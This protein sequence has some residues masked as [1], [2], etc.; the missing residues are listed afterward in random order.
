MF[1][2]Y[3]SS[4]PFINCNGIKFWSKNNQQHRDNDQPAV[5]RA[6]GSMY[7]FKNGQQHRDNDQPAV[8]YS[9]GDK[10]WYKNGKLIKKETK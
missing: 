2:N 5:V 3:K 4:R 6:D 8:V 7:W 10:Y 1:T 9:D